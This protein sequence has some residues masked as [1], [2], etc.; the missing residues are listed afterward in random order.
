MLEAFMSETTIHSIHVLSNADSSITKLCLKHGFE[1]RETPYEEAISLISACENR[2]FANVSNDL[3]MQGCFLRNIDDATGYFGDPSPLL[4]IK[5]SFTCDVPCAK[6]LLCDNPSSNNLQTHFSNVREYLHPAISSLKL[7]V[8]SDINIVAEYLFYYQNDEVELI[9]TCKPM[10]YLLSDPNIFVLNESQLMAAQNF[11]DEFSY[12]S[13]KS[14]QKAY[15]FFKQSYLTDNIDSAF[16]S[17]MIC[18]E[19]LFSPDDMKE[20]ANRISRGVAILVGNN[21]EESTH[22]Y[23]EMKSLYKFRSKLVHAG[24]SVN[25]PTLNIARK[26]ARESIKCLLNI[27]DRYRGDNFEVFKNELDKCGF[28][29][30]PWS[31]I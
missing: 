11:I 23:S 7:F 27:E 9:R 21:E 14:L 18:F 26:Y 12:P 22:I 8:E 28:I 17:I 15:G 29:R 31:A 1:I 2:P 4:L 3:Q 25:K 10:Y 6:K 24:V 13:N 19:I 5:T 20:L 16:V 30:K